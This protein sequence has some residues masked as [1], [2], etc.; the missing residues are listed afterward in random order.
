[1][2]AF[3]T[4]AFLFAAC[5]AVAQDHSGGGGA[6]EASSRFERADVFALEHAADPRVSPDGELVAYTRVSGD[7]MTD[8]FRR[9]VW[10]VGADG[11]GHRA[12]VQD[13]GGAGSPRWSPSGDRLLFTS[14]EGGKAR[15]CVL[16][17]E[18]HTVTVVAE[19]ARG[20]S[21]PAW[22]PD[23]AWIAFLMFTEGEGPAPVELP[24]KPEGRS[25]ARRR[26]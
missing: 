18:T 14:S 24:A 21:S 15:L 4:A 16:D 22:S 26:W 23:G 3:V 20:A 2:R 10:V 19:L 11:S 17:M 7:I 25:G 13:D 1:M 5:S 6:A 8:R 9:S 12:L